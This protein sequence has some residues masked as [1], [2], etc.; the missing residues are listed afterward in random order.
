M[1]AKV[2]GGVSLPGQKSDRPACESCHGQAPHTAE[3]GNKL[4][5]HVDKVACQTCHIPAFARGGHATKVYWDWSTAGRLDEKGKPI[6]E[7]KD[8]LVTYDGMKGSFEW[9]E[10]VTPEYFWFDGSVRHTLLGDRIDSGETTE[11]NQI[12]GGYA[13]TK[14]RIWPF[15]VMRG[16]QPYDKGNDILVVSHLFGK[17]GDAFWKSFD[18]DKA[19]RAGME[20]AKRVGQTTM[21]YSGEYGFTDTLMYWPITHMV[22]PA[23]QAL[24]CADC[25]ARDGRLAT[26][27]GFYMPGR[28]RNPW[29]D[30]IGWILVAATLAGVLLHGL[31]RVVSR[32]KT[33]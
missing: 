19:L 21:D 31:V 26:L 5:S 29:I 32:K 22:A 4:N 13:D 8:G 30:R 1:K 3:I 24:G 14:A 20:E 25:H 33:A 10:N 27:T 2:E 11:L 28:D 6:K 18:W 9:A 12:A 16:R 15:K 23:D 7:V 17:D